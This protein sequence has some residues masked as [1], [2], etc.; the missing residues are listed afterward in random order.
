M[1]II[2]PNAN[3]VPLMISS[4]CVNCFPAVNQPATFIYGGNG[5]CLDCFKAAKTKIVSVSTE[6]TD[7]EIR[8]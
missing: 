3:Q 8:G 1:T 6:K 7:G 5:L 2:N 4:I